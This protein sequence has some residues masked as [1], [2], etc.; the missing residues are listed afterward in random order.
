MD[1]WIQIKTKPKVSPPYFYLNWDT[2]KSHPIKQAYWLNEMPKDA[3]INFKKTV[4]WKDLKSNITLIASFPDDFSQKL[5]DKDFKYNNI[6]NFYEDDLPPCSDIPF[7]K[8]HLQKAIRRSKADKAVKTAYNLMDLDF[9]HFIRRIIIIMIEDVH[10][11][12]SIN[13]LT[14]MMLAYNSWKPA[15]NHIQWILGVV[16]F[17]ANSEYREIPERTEKLYLQTYFQE[18]SKIKR[19]SYRSTLWSVLIRK[20]YGGMPGDI[21]MLNHFINK[22]LNIFH[23]NCNNKNKN[24]TNLDY[25]HQNFR[26]VDSELDKL[27]ITEWIPNAIDF[28]CCPNILYSIQSNFWE[29]NYEDIDIKKAIWE[30]SSKITNKKDLNEDNEGNKDNKNKNCTDDNENIE[31]YKSIWKNIEKE[32]YKIAYG[33]LRKKIT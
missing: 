30:F 7:L 24:I 26:A 3:K 20:S 2:E 6:Y 17:L 11:H 16:A 13:T 4:N 10:I 25:Y 1:K 32:Y 12:K 28:H 21:E 8:S 31:I 19:K 23:N 18:I 27:T 9:N 14:W 22:Y 15:K 33:M 5:N 29:E